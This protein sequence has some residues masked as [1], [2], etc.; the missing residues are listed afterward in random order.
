MHSKFRDSEKKLASEAK[1]YV[2]FIQ[3]FIFLLFLYFQPMKV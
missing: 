3:V 1:S 2:T